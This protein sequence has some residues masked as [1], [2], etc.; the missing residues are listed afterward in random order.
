MKTIPSQN[1]HKTVSIFIYNHTQKRHST[2][3]IKF[4]VQVP[5]P[6]IPFTLNSTSASASKEPTCDS[7]IY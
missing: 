1:K 4:S 3:F 2:L 7:I 6:D 5:I